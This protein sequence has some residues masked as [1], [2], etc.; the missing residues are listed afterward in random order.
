MTQ[1][2]TQH[3]KANKL[4]RPTGLEPLFGWLSTLQRSQAKRIRA[5]T[6]E[7]LFERPTL[8]FSLARTEFSLFTTRQ[9][10]QPCTYWLW[11][12]KD[13]VWE[14]YNEPLESL[15]LWLREREQQSCKA[16]GAKR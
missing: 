14:V 16:W 7:P 9:P 1:L 13:Q 10:G 15:F 3:A 11:N 12:W 5:Q 6:G 2:R 8:R 4:F